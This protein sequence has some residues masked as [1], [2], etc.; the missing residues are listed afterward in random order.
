MASRCASYVDDTEQ[1]NIAMTFLEKID[2]SNLDDCIINTTQMLY[3]LHIYDV[4]LELYQRKMY[5]HGKHS[6]IAFYYNTIWQDINTNNNTN[7][8]Y[9]DIHCV[10]LNTS[11]N[12]CVYRLYSINT[13]CTIQI[14]QN[15]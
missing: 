10:H 13:H 14:V 2:L 12:F 5:V 7:L 9:S 6:S 1:C 15:I 8:V 11:I 4:A 3:C